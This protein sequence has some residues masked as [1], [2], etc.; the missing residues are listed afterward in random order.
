MEVLQPLLSWAVPQR[1]DA[2]SSVSGTFGPPALQSQQR[3]PLLDWRAALAASQAARISRDQ[4]LAL[5]P[6]EQGPI[7]SD[8]LPSQR[9]GTRHNLAI[10]ASNRPASSSLCHPTDPTASHLPDLT[11]MDN[12]TD[13]AQP[14]PSPPSHLHSNHSPNPIAARLSKS[15]VP[16][17][18]RPNNSQAEACGETRRTTS[19]A[20]SHQGPSAS[21]GLPQ[22]VEAAAWSTAPGAAALPP[23]L[24]AW[25]ILLLGPPAAQTSGAPAPGRACRSPVTSS[26][27]NDG[28]AGSCKQQTSDSEVESSRSRGH[29][30]RYGRRS[31][32]GAVHMSPSG[33]GLLLPKRSTDPS[34]SQPSSPRAT[35]ATTAATAISPQAE[36]GTQTDYVCAA[37]SGSDNT[38]LDPVGGG[39]LTNRVLNRRRSYTVLYVR[40]YD[41]DDDGR[42][43]P[44]PSPGSGDSSAGLQAGAPAG[45]V[46]GAVGAAVSAAI[47]SRRR[48]EREPPPQQQT[49]SQAPP[50][51]AVTGDPGGRLE[52]TASPGGIDG[53]S[54]SVGLTDASQHLPKSTS[55]SSSSSGAHRHSSSPRSGPSA[56]ASRVTASEPAHLET[57]PVGEDTATTTTT[58]AAAAAALEANQAL[59]A[60]PVIGD[61]NAGDGVDAVAGVGSSGPIAGGETN[62]AQK[63]AMVSEPAMGTRL[64]PQGPARDVVSGRTPVRLGAAWEAALGVDPLVAVA[65]TAWAAPAPAPAQATR[66]KPKRAPLEPPS[67]AAEAEEA[68]SLAG[69]EPVMRWRQRSRTDQEAKRPLTLPANSAQAARAAGGG[70][71]AAGSRKGGRAD[72]TSPQRSVPLWT[73]HKLAAPPPPRGDGGG[74]VLPPPPAASAGSKF[75]AADATA[76]VAAQVDT[77]PRFRRDRRRPGMGCAAAA[78]ARAIAAAGG[79]GASASSGVRRWVPTRTGLRARVLVRRKVHASGGGGGGVNLHPGCGN[80]ALG[81]R[82]V[83]LVQRLLLTALAALAALWAALLHG[84]DAK[85]TGT[86]NPTITPMPTAKT[87]ATTAPTMSAMLTAAAAVAAAAAVPLMVIM[88]SE[89]TAPVALTYHP[90]RRSPLSAHPP[91]LRQLQRPLGVLGMMGLM[92]M[93]MVMQGV[94]SSA[95]RYRSPYGRRCCRNPRGRRRNAAMAMCLSIMQ[96]RVC[97]RARRLEGGEARRLQPRY[98]VRP[99]A[100]ATR[101]FT[102]VEDGT[103]AAASGHVVQPAVATVGSGVLPSSLS[104]AASWLGALDGRM[105]RQRTAESAQQVASGGPTVAV[106]GTAATAASFSGNAG[107]NR[108]PLREA[109]HPAEPP[110]PPPPPALQ[111]SEVSAKTTGAR[112]TGPWPLGGKT[113]FAGRQASQPLTSDLAD[114]GGGSHSRVSGGTAMQYAD[115]SAPSA[116]SSDSTT[117]AA[118]AASMASSRPWPIT[119]LL[120][121]GSG[122]PSAATSDK[123]LPP[124]QLLPPPPQRRAEPLLKEEEVEKE[125]QLAQWLKEHTLASGTVAP[126]QPIQVIVTGPTTTILT[127]SINIISIISISAHKYNNKYNNANNNKYNNANKNTHHSSSRPGSRALWWLTSCSSYPQPS[128][129]QASFGYTS[130][131]GDS[132]VG[133]VHLA[134]GAGVE[135]TVKLTGLSGARAAAV[136]Q[137]P[138]MLVY[139]DTRHSGDHASTMYGIQRGSQG[140]P[141]K[142]HRPTKEATETSVGVSPHI[143]R[144]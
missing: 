58:A 128:P 104:F 85:A 7:T 127:T 32:D 129:T 18:G 135:V 98:A 12:A 136:E 57:T 44:V 55:S 46:A 142:A 138:P 41:Y 71:V 77:P 139:G 108:P 17:A 19:P 80:G 137:P 10:A 118:A 124:G 76:E 22:C 3:R 125:G 81:Q 51:A 115:L 122:P 34:P 60:G 11:Q 89:T 83:H 70:C 48:Q 110:P 8:S 61:A 126:S 13:A 5:Q 6:L 119:G 2:S 21:S 105:S 24:A 45:E 35:A 56:V 90:S 78:V 29:R 47:G 130:G 65:R 121:V 16:A 86:I 143:A 120:S 123:L 116:P 79:C 84:R 4:R 43:A 25:G 144:Y 102:A 52:G 68:Q 82:G 15:P 88:L 27:S 99:P 36:R 100:A 1:P 134:G 42:P 74:D 28:D 109:V 96:R 67:A 9:C 23:P 38:V 64:R 30:Y 40:D 111:P 53:V 101:G 94:P 62:E 33:D 66:T 73:A 37:Q 97:Q 49:P 106:A 95:D 20:P 26:R 117:A 107:G 92:V 93:V 14:P 72:V 141:G 91:A 31:H 133:V 69:P 113:S 75:T 131:P 87:A 63:M 50:D 140:G 59:H 103:A 132:A 54:P 39:P 112:R 114:S